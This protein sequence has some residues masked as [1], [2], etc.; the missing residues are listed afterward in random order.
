MRV[1]FTIR[2]SLR[3]GSAED[4]GAQ[5][6]RQHSEADRD[7]HAAQQA[8]RGVRTDEGG[9]HRVHEVA[10]ILDDMEELLGER[11]LN[12]AVRAGG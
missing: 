7:Q 1:R 8:R 11:V 6:H 2:A 4:P 9:A 3:G 12:Y 5:N 10:E